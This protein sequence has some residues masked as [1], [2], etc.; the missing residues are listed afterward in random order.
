MVSEKRRDVH[1]FDLE[2]AGARK[3]L[4]TPELTLEGLR[5]WVVIDE[6]QRL[7]SLFERICLTW[8]YS[9]VLKNRA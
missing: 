7:P 9:R 2:R 1:Y 8:R 3:A 6:I 4:S 5:G